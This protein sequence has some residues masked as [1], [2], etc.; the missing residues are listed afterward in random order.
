MKHFVAGSGGRYV[1]SEDFVNLQELALSIKSIFDGCDN[2][3]ISGCTVS[4]S[5]ISAGYVWLNGQIRH[6]SGASGF[7]YPYYIYESNSYT[8]TEYKDEPNKTGCVNYLCAGGTSVPT[9]N[10]AVT[11]L[12]PASITITSAYTPRIQDKFFGKYSLILN[13][14]SA[15]QTVGKE[16][17]FSSMVT[18]N[19]GVTAN[20][21]VS[22][23]SKATG[24]AIKSMFKANGQA[25]V[26][27]WLN[28]ALVTDIVMTS[29]GAVKVFKG[30]T[31]IAS[32]TDSRMTVNKEFYAPKVR[33]SALAF[34]ANEIFNETDTSDTGAVLVNFVGLNGG[35][36]KFRDFSVYDG[37]KTR[38][39]HVDGKNKALH[40]DAAIKASH[41]GDGLVLTNKSKNKSD[42]GLKNAIYLNALDGAIGSIG[43][44]DGLTNTFS[45]TSVLGDIL[46]TPKAAVNIS[47]I[48]QVNGK[49]IADIYVNKTTYDTAI[50]KKVDKVDGMGLSQESFTTVHKKKLDGIVF[51]NVETNTDGL[52]N[53]SYVQGLANGRLEKDKNLSDLS[54]KNTARANLGVYSTQEIVDMLAKKLDSDKA[55]DG[56]IF[57][58]D[59]KTKLEEIKSGRFESVDGEGQVV[60][61]VNGYITTNQILYELT[62]YAPK[63]LDKYT[64]SEKAQVAVNLSV[65]STKEADKK[66]MVPSSLM[67]DYLAHLTGVMGKTTDEAKSILRGKIG[68]ASTASLN[69]YVTK[70]GLLSDLEL[71]DDAAKK[72]VCNRLGA[73]YAADYQTKINDTGWIALSVGGLYARQIGNIVCIQGKFTASFKSDSL[74]F[75]LP[76]QIQPPAYAVQ[77]SQPQIGSY[78]NDR[79]FIARIEGGARRCTVIENRLSGYNMAFTLT[80]MV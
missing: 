61:K 79:N 44:A 65:Y 25:S 36:T 14:P 74:M 56:E 35:V 41:T 75:E 54:N 11:N 27:L 26:G 21:P 29:D 49:N 10:D 7:Q 76:N 59:H 23:V 20:Q 40:I 17:E 34:S 69:S 24:Y 77:F 2:F 53:M 55:Y 1:Y 50:G 42:A 60:P 8:S 6:F 78:S 30:S 22:V 12:P 68:A 18:A 39:L 80:Y 73:A 57:T 28:N 70:T 37:Q 38:V 71:K 16:V 45:I 4:G 31:E 13:T 5:N 51:A 46:I 52:V 48:L 33:T 62:K 43:Y 63:M 47:G 64:E 19:Q 3:V 58:T 72:T 9:E 32:F 66:F 15:K 67:D